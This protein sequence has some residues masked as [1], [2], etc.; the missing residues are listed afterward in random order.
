[1]VVIGID[2]GGT[3][4]KGGLV[5][6]DGALTGVQSVRTPVEEGRDGILNNL[7]GLVKA[8][9]DSADEP[10]EA[11]GIGS[12]GRIDHI[13]GSVFYAT[14]NLPGWTGTP[15]AA[16]VQE[17]CGL[18]A[19]VDNDV[20]VAAVGEAWI[21]AAAQYRNFAFVALGTGV[22]GAIVSDGQLLHG[23]FGGAGE[24]GHLILHPFGLPCNCGQAGCFEQYASGTA[25]NRIAHGIN[26]DWD[27]RTLV[28]R[29]AAGDAK[30]VEAIEGFVRDLAVGLVSIR[31]AVDPSVIVLGGGLIDAKHVWWDRLLQALKEAT[32]KQLPIAAATLGNRAG[33]VGAAK[34]ALDR[35]AK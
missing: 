25:L 10:V 20:N 1:M 26:P 22:G 23:E 14:D 9:Q 24:V 27:S 16:L 19:F 30:A 28:E 5:S 31:N 17:H 7:Y 13:N 32:P 3:G 35:I 29:C 2:L 6:A 21:G 11:V 4:I 34:I 12:A 8:L 18:P 33:M 15:I